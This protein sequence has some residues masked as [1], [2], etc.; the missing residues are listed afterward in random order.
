MTEINQIY[1]CNVCGNITEMVHGGI[2]EMICCGQPME[3]SR[4]KNEDEGLEKHK[5]VVEK[6]DIGVIVRIGSVPHP[7]E[8]EHYIEWIEII[9]EH[10]T[11]RKHLEPGAAPEAEFCL[12]AE[13]IKARA[14]CN[15]HGL[16]FS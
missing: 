10:R 12:E 4:E 7:M 5:P 13:H 9:T 8:S 3:L 11:Y 15:V 14:Y 2:G 1:K 6:T 16:W